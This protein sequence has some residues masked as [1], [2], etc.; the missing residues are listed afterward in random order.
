MYFSG[1]LWLQTSVY[2]L[3]NCE[4]MGYISAVLFVVKIRVQEGEL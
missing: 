3:N 2:R 1:H 4:T